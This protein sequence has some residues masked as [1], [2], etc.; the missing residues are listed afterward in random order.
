MSLVSRLAPR[1]ASGFGYGSTAEQVCEGLDLTGRT[2]LITGCNSGLGLESFRVLAARGA[3][4]LAAARSE[5]KA[6]EA[7]RTVGGEHVPLAC[8]LSEP[9]S[10]LACVAAVRALDRPVDVLLLNAGIMALPNLETRH[11]LEMQFLT[12]HVGHF[13]LTT[14]LLD[15]LAPNA[16]VVAL[17]SRAHEMPVKGGID[18]TNLDGA[19]GYNPWTF[20][21][22]SK[23]A[24]LLFARELG[25]RFEGSGR[26]ANAVHPGVIQTNLVRH[27]GGTL[28]TLFGMTKSLFAKSVEEGAATQCWAAVHPGSAGFQGAYFADCNDARSTAYGRDMALAA[29]LWSRTEAIVAPWVR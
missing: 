7:C 23:L 24:N 6:A 1:G 9:E 18:F 22:Q 12:N 29:E 20:Y 4:I 3:T 26:I 28:N 25:R 5:A 21:G 8:E 15:T 2:I 17:S 11:G 19:R 14:G 10:V 13:L 16:R 27:M